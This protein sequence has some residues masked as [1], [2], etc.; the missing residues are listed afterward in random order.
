MIIPRKDKRKH[1]RCGPTHTAG[2]ELFSAMMPPAQW[3]CREVLRVQS[4]YPDKDICFYMDRACV[5]REMCGVVSTL[6]GG[7]I[8][9]IL[10]ADLTTIPR[11]LRYF[12]DVTASG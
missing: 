3:Y 1:R 4:L 10:D 7:D 8:L 2:Q 6:P 5:S 9:I 12:M 11:E